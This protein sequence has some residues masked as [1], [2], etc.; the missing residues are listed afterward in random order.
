MVLRSTRRLHAFV[1]QGQQSPAGHHKPSLWSEIN[2]KSRDKPSAVQQVDLTVDNIRDSFFN[3][4]P[5]DSQL[6]PMTAVMGARYRGHFNAFERPPSFV[7]TSFENGKTNNLGKPVRQRIGAY[8][9]IPGL[10]LPQIRTNGEPLGIGQYLDACVGVDERSWAAPAALPAQ[11]SAEALAREFGVAVLILGHEQACH[12]VARFRPGMNMEFVREPVQF[13]NDHLINLRCGNLGNGFASSADAQQQLIQ[14]FF[15]SVWK[16][17]SECPH[18]R[19]ASTWWYRLDEVAK[20]A[21]LH[22]HTILPS[23]PVEC[24]SSPDAC[25]L[26]SAS[27]PRWTQLPSVKLLRNLK[28]NDRPEYLAKEMRYGLL[29]LN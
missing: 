28:W 22:D 13:L 25:D 11:S 3:Y 6:A 20:T 29:E 24:S 8:Y 12:F 21:L 2:S 15:G 27:D 26:V 18:F 10:P 23:T 7:I 4:L 17:A 1:Q 19:Q 5:Q 14:S 9:A 16:S